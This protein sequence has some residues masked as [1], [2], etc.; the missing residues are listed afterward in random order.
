[1]GIRSSVGFGWLADS[2]RYLVDEDETMKRLIAAIAT[3]MLTLMVSNA[4]AES[5]HVYHGFAQGNSDLSQWGTRDDGMTGVQPGIGDS[6]AT[7]RSSRSDRGRL[8]STKG[9]AGSNMDD[10]GTGLPSIYGG[11]GGSDLSW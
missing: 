1:M 11:F 6:A 8:F 2:F 9:G 3:T 10:R 7:D 5:D 4:G